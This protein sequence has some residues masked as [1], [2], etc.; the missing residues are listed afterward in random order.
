MERNSIKHLLMS[1]NYFVL[2]KKLVKI[3]GIETAFFLT[4]LA[5]ADE[6]LAD[7]DGWFYQTVPQMQEVTGLSEHKQNSYCSL[8]IVLLNFFPFYPPFREIICLFNL[9]YF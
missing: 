9:L 8:I 2:N 3:L 4:S 1:S 7:K 5:E 6:M